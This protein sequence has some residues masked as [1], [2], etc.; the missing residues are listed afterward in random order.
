VEAVR[1]AVPPGSRLVVPQPWGSWFEYALPEMP[2]FVD[3][4]IELFPTELWYEYQDLRGTGAAWREVLDRW[5]ADAIV[6]D[7][8]DWTLQDELRDDPG[9]R[10]V[11]EDEESAVFVRA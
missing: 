10:L 9:W 4:R 7:L 11:Y 6:V 5:E 8:R 1:E 3:P 2:L